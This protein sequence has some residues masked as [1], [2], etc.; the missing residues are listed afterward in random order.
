MIIR[1]SPAIILSSIEGEYFILHYCNYSNINAAL[2][3]IILLVIRKKGKMDGVSV[4]SEREAALF[5]SL[6]RITGA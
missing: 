5:H 4:F 2:T 6:L 3:T 1:R